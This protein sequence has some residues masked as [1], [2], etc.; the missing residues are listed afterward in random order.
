MEPE[1]KEEPTAD[2]MHAAVD[3]LFKEEASDEHKAKKLKKIWLAMHEKE[4]KE[5]ATEEKP[6]AKECEEK[7]ADTEEE[8][9]EKEEAAAKER[10]AHEQY[11][12]RTE[13]TVPSERPGID[14]ARGILKHVHIAGMV[15]RNDGARYKIEAHRKAGPRFEQMPVGLDHDY[16]GAPL[17]VSQAWGILSNITVES[18]GPYGDLSYLK[19]HERTEQVLED[20]ERGTGIF[21]LS[22]VAKT[23]GRGLDIDEYVP[24]R[25]DLVVRGATTRT[26]FNQESNFVTKEKFEQL[27]AEIAELKKRIELKETI[28]DSHRLEQEINRVESKAYAKFDPKTFWDKSIKASK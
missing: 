8:I 24:S 2:A 3:S 17:K 11:I 1:V 15:S 23:K 4:E 25:V 5:E 20:A 16:T 21:S 19:S 14:R 9:R 22:M 6:E 18:D 26:L 27:Q 13:Q 28:V 7:E 12:E 10:E